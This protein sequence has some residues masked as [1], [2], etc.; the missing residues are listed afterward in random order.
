MLFRH[1]EDTCTFTVPSGE[2]FQASMSSITAAGADPIFDAMHQAILSLEHEIES[3]AINDPNL[4]VGTRDKILCLES[5]S[6]ALRER[7]EM[8]EGAAGADV[9][10]LAAAAKAAKAARAADKA[11]YEAV[12]A[13][14]RAEV[15]RL[16]GG[17]A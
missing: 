1:D 2:C 10:D 3:F 5:E 11:G 14:L 13:D 9:A 4:I 8:L 15:A 12:I 16:K 7:V 6:A 17:A